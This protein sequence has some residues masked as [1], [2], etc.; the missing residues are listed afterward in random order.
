VQAAWPKRV[1]VEAVVEATRAANPVVLE[2]GHAHVEYPR[3]VSGL[4]CRVGA[5]WVPVRSPSVAVAEGESWMWAGRL[6]L[7]SEVLHR[8]ARWLGSDLSGPFS[9]VVRMAASDVWG[10]PFAEQLQGT[11]RLFDRHLEPWVEHLG[12]FE[13]ALED[14]TREAEVAARAEASGVAAPFDLEGVLARWRLWPPAQWPL[15]PGWAAPGGRPATFVWVYPERARQLAVGLRQVAQQL[16][17]C[18]NRL[19]NGLA[20][21]R[22]DAPPCFEPLAGGAEA[23][24]AE[25]DRRVAALKEADRRVAGSFGELGAGLGFPGALA[26]PPH[27]NPADPLGSAVPGASLPVG[28]GPGRQPTQA[29]EA[30]PVSVAT[31]NYRHEALD[32]AMGGRGLPT[33]FVRTYNS[34]RAGENGPLGYGWSTNLGAFLRVEEA[35]VAVC[36]GDGRDEHHRREASG[37]L[38]APAGS[39]GRLEVDGDG[40]VLRHDDGT[41]SRFDGS[42]RLLGMAD[43]AD[44][45]T[46]LDYE[47]GRLTRVVDPA[48]RETCFEHD[49]TG[50]IT[51]MVDGLG[52]RFEYRYDRRDDLVGVTDASGGEWSYRYDEAHRLTAITDPEDRTV[53]TNVYDPA[54][55]VVEQRDG[56]GSIWRYVYGSGRTVVTDPLGDK[57]SYQHDARFRTVCMTDPLGAITRFAW[58][59]DDRLVA[60][61]DPA[62]GRLTFAFDERGN[63][64]GATGTGTDPVRFEWDDDDNL[65]AV[66]AATGERATLSYDEADR[67]VR[68][69]SP[70]AVETHWSW[71]PDGLLE[72]VA[73]GDG[74]TTRYGYDDVGHLASVTD[75]L[76]ATTTV[77]FDRAGRPASEDHP[78]GAHTAFAWDAMGRLVSVTDAQGA[79]TH[80]EYDRSGLL[81]AVTDGLGRT[82]RYAYEERGLLASVTDPIGRVT[83]FAYDACGRLA[84]RNDPRGVAVHYGYDPAG[85]LVGIEAPGLEPISFTWDPAGRLTSVADGTGTTSFDCGDAGGPVVERHDRSG[86]ALAHA[87]DRL[88]R[89]VRLELSRHGQPLAA[90]VYGYDTDGRLTRVVDPADG[91]THLTFD[92]AG[93]LTEV[94]HPNGVTTTWSYDLAGQPAALTVAGPAG[95]L[96]DWALVHD[97]DGNRT[98]ATR[99]PGPGTQSVTSTYGYDPL[100]RLL[101][102]DDPSGAAAFSWDT[103]GNLLGGNAE[104]VYDAADQLVADGTATYR[105]DAA[106]NLTARAPTNDSAPRSCHYDSLGRPD[107]LT[108]AGQDV[109]FAYDGLGRRVSRTDHAGRTLRVYDGASVIAELDDHG[110]PTFE[111]TAALLVLSRHG[112]SGHRYLHPDPTTSV[113]EVTDDTGAIVARFRYTPFGVRATTDGDSH[114]AGPLGFCGTLGVREEASSLL[115]MRARLY[116][117]HLG[118]FTSPDPWPP[119]LP[120]PLT[121][122]RYLYALG[123]PISQVDPYGLFCLT[124]K[125]DKGK[126]RG[127]KDVVTRTGDV[128]EEPLGVVSTVATGVA[129]VA[130]GVSLYCPPCVVVSGPVAGFAGQTAF[131][132]G[133]AAAASSCAADWSFSFD[134]GVKVA[135][136]SAGY[137]FKH[138]SKVGAEVLRLTG[139]DVFARGIFG[140]F[141]SGATS[142]ARRMRK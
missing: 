127:L 106:G 105:H 77:R 22:I 140:L 24:A 78:G 137:A 43:P 136:S 47:E 73:E 44:N 11:I 95:T 30:D 58:D 101:R 92:P 26:P 67:P 54:G 40:F 41:V 80:L 130:A 15:D 99:R 21:L 116:D 107:R 66:V 4:Q 10:G 60:V 138:L 31:G 5:R 16:R 113:S 74:G 125:N 129:A 59:D 114:A 141:R 108:V 89:R 103:A 111:T 81:V 55:R 61:V 91:E 90:W 19:G 6:R 34:L 42:G 124:G 79:V 68:F 87:Y 52:G 53:V 39:S 117:P 85:R 86:I 18:R 132:T 25:V 23:V 110:N 93:R 97:T 8:E 50:R 35:A 121:L 102:A 32:L 29:T 69:V 12:R 120:E 49:R 131:F 57:R 135:S 38:A 56:A 109:T 27:T 75:P 45:E 71:R 1:V 9:M 88:G 3:V 48:G 134:C 76:G 142:A 133:I 46:L 100:G 63:L 64:V 84:A 126:C 112:P 14:A 65:T 37:A 7:A 94:A 119:N 83:T 82:T 13:R 122:N 2:G 51:A 28:A 139:A 70:A 123:D 128:L 98:Q 36:S 96:S 62:G 20:P 115:D 17:A 72:A 118:R 104:T 33:M